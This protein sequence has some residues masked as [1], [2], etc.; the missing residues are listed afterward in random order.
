MAVTLIRGDH[1]HAYRLYPSVDDR[2]NGGG[3]NLA[4][5]ITTQTKLVACTAY[6]DINW[7][8]SR[9]DQDGG[10]VVSTNVDVTGNQAVGGDQ[11]VGGTLDVNGAAT[12]PM[13]SPL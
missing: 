12:L 8:C 7:V 3:A 4:A 11:T 1:T 13:M 2:I 9:V 6:D 10:S 5:E